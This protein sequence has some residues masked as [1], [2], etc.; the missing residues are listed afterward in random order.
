M[1]PPELTTPATADKS[2]PDAPASSQ[3]P[4]PESAPK[5]RGGL[6][7]GF[8]AIALAVGAFFYWQHSGGTGGAQSGTTRTQVV[9]VARV[10]REDLAESLTM[11]AE[12]RPYQQAALHAKIAG[13]LQS[14]S[15]DVGDHVKEGQA[16][17]Q[18]DVPELKHDLEKAT[19]SHRAS[20]QEVL[21]AEASYNEAYLAS[22]RLQGVA[23]QNAKLVAEQELDAVLAKEA[24]TAGALD[25]AKQRIQE[26]QAEVNKVR[27]MI[28]YTTITAPFDGVITRRYVDTGA[29]VPAGTSSSAQVPVVD[30]AEDKRL[31]LA[32]PVPESAVSLV[33]VDAPVRITVSSL[34]V[35][36]EGKVSRFSGKVDRATRTMST[37]V[38]VDNSD[39]RLKPGMYARVA[40]VVRE[41]K[42]AVAVP[43]QGITVGEKP[44]VLIVSKSGTVEERR[45]K[46]GLQTPEK[47]EVLSGLEPGEMVI[48][49]SRSGIQPGQKVTAK[50][51]E[52]TPAE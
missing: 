12:F 17:A 24:S 25:A 47:A 31:R 13:F 3:I 20:E 27:S 9:A 2:A 16:I 10:S 38:A 11:A 40:L 39:G 7:L 8:A 22:Q 46:L 45:V 44:S 51:I 29:L 52:L 34:G 33:K 30:I 50:V 36:I 42:G 43:V 5:K 14:I 26:C 18:L 21:R 15:V 37:E 4:Q 48:V 41:S 23:K 28:T 32:F 35:T 19:A 6:I 1:I 49:G